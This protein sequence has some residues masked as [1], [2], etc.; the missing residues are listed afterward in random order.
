MKTLIE[1]NSLIFATILSILAILTFAGFFATS[2]ATGPDKLVEVLKNPLRLFTW[3]SIFYLFFSTGLA[4]SYFTQI[5]NYSFLKIGFYF[6]LL[7]ALIQLILSFSSWE[8]LYII[9][10]AFGGIFLM[11]EAIILKNH[12]EKVMKIN[13][14][15]N[16]RESLYFL[17]LF[18]AK[19]STELNQAFKIMKKI[20]LSSPLEEQISGTYRL[21]FLLEK[22]F[23]AI[24]EQKEVKLTIQGKKFIEEK[25]GKF[26]FAVNFEEWLNLMNLWQR[27]ERKEFEKVRDRFEEISKMPLQE[28]I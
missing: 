9:Q 23:I 6:S 17:Y 11:V 3:I 14:L 7:H 8:N 28:L 19:D 21:N 16:L 12:S 2:D 1:K 26:Y 13:A 4:F 5:K 22:K 18:E 15:Q 10:L 27:K 24:N 20:N 25:K